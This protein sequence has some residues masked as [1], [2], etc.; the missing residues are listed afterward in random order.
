M[1]EK[2]MVP[3]LISYCKYRQSIYQI[4]DCLLHSIILSNFLNAGAIFIDY[5]SHVGHY[6]FD[7]TLASVIICNFILVA[8]LLILMVTAKQMI[9]STLNTSNKERESSD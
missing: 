8:L 9:V 4:I 6:N 3:S 1:P 2:T 7:V 5:I